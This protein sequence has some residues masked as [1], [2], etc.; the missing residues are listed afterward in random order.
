MKV[1]IIL[2]L[3]F[4]AIASCKHPLQIVGEGDIVELNDGARGCT[5]EEFQAQATRCTDNDVVGDYNVLYEAQPR[6]GWRFVSWNGACGNVP[7]GQCAVNVPAAF[8]AFWDDTFPGVPAPALVAT[9]E[10]ADFVGQDQSF[11]GA[12]FG[13]DDD[14]AF[15]ALLRATLFADGRFRYETVL[16]SA[17]FDDSLGSG[18]YE[19]EDDGL[20]SV[21]GSD[22]DFSAG[23]VATAEFDL[24]ALV[25]VDPSDDEISVA[26][27]TEIQSDASAATLNG[28]YFCG[29]IDSDLA[30]SFAQAILNGDGTGTVNVLESTSGVTGGGAATY[31]VTSEGRVTLNFLGARVVGGVADNGNVVALTQTQ[32]AT[33]GAGMCI[34]ASTAQS[35]AQVVGEYYGAY[36]DTS[37]STAI[38]DFRVFSDGSANYTVVADSFGG[39]IT[40]PVQ[41]P[42]S[43]QPNG[44]ISTGFEQGMVSSDGRIAF[45]MNSRPGGLPELAVYIRKTD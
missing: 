12:V 16:E 27:L 36:A 24:V 40:L 22:S 11:L 19:R 33:Q 5:L 20:M 35:L 37:A 17:D 41:L 28:E 38:R 15:S 7:L 18:F 21:S 23:G 34:R 29:F 45:L 8:P 9:F 43:V 31:S 42:F 1:R 32:S 44:R 14:D 30:G 2:V 25:D 6:P 4:L 10:P 3:S 26:Y 39:L 13:V